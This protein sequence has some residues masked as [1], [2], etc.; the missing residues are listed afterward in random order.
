MDTQKTR[1]YDE[2]GLYAHNILDTI[3]TSMGN[4]NMKAHVISQREK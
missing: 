2:I 4:E 3:P 1:I